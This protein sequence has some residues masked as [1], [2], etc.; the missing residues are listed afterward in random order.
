LNVSIT[1]MDMHEMVQVK[2]LLDSSTTGMFIDQQ[3]VHQNRLKT[4]ILLFPIK[5]YNVD[6]SLNQGGLITEEVTLMM[7][8]RGHKEKAT[9]K[10]CDLGKAVI[11]VGHPWL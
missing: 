8:H 3:F 7:S 11:I 2:A 9:N 5:V 4:Q 10:V 1:T 6:G